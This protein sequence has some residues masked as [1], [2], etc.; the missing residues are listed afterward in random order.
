MSLLS[1]PTFVRDEGLAGTVQFLAR[2]AREPGG[3]Q[4][5]SV[6]WRIFQRY[7]RNLGA[8]ALVARKRPA[9]DGV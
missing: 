4:R 9:P 3:P 5:L 7:R 2:T 1:P 6:I 8:V